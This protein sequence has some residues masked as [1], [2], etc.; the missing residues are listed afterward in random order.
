[1]PDIPLV[2]IDRSP[3]RIWY[4]DSAHDDAGPVGRIRV[5]GHADT[6]VG[7]RVD[8]LLSVALRS[9]GFKGFAGYGVAELRADDEAHAG[10][11]GAAARTLVNDLTEL[12][13][14]HPRFVEMR[15]VTQFDA[16]QAPDSVTLHFRSPD[17]GP[18][19]LKAGTASLPAGVA[20]AAGSIVSNPGE[21]SWQRLAMW[22]CGNDA[23]ASRNVFFRRQGASVEALYVVVGPY[24]TYPPDPREKAKASV[25]IASPAEPIATAGGVQP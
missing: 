22:F 18:A 11:Y 8:E 15:P 10:Q 2:A 14:E 25:L 24:L 23:A 1:V 12:A 4:E 5:V 13:S 17:A 3:V 6:T 9:P 20:L 16:D 21:D 19:F 7:E